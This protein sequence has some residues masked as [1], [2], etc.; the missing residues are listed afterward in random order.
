MKTIVA[1]ALGECVHVAGVHSFL[2]LAEQNGWR[3]IFL[4]PANSIQQV[5]EAAEKENADL[6][7][8]SYRLTPENGERLLAEFA[9][10]ADDL[11]SRGVKF[12]FGGTPP[13]VDRIKRLNFFE[14]HFDGSERIEEITAYLRGQDISSAQ[15]DD[16]PQSAIERIRWKSPYPL[17]R[18]HYG[19]PDLEE[20]IQ[21]IEAIAESK[22]IDV[23]SLGIDQDA[24]ENFFHPERQDIRRRGAGGVPVR[25]AEDY[26][27]LYEATR[28]GNFPLIRTYS[29]T[30]DFIRLAEMYVKTINIAWAAVPLYW[31][32]QMD[33][34][35]PWDLE[36]S[37]REHIRLMRWYGER[38]IPVEANEAH[39]WGMRDAHDVVFVVSAYLAAYNAKA[40]GVNDHIVQLMF[41]SPPG[42]SVV[43]DLAKMIAVIDMT[44]PLVSPE[45]RIW[46]QVRTG[47]LSYP[48]DLDQAR[49]HLAI[50]VFNQMQ[51]NPDIVHVVGYPEANHAVTANEVI[52][53]CMMAR[54]AID[55]AIA[56]QINVINSESIQ[57]R[58]RELVSEAGVLVKEI[59]KL[60][61]GISADPL[62]DPK[63]LA[64][65]VTSGLLDAPQLSNNQYGKGEV[66]TSFDHRGACLAIDK[67]SGKAL[68]E[69]QRLTSMQSRR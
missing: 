23:I 21:G 27:R 41:N 17:I 39:H 11:R 67:A 44:S 63:V 5:I 7:G 38:N 20:T 52:E 40:A 35:G 2:K 60:G 37:I 1:S 8:V 68:S 62:A 6:V 58:V 61:S 49:A 33:G 66:V 15:E 25:S 4:G 36:G 13:V 26:S 18:H 28:T 56:S 55:D 9:E 12:A 24:Q 64:K 57:H 54:K 59:H 43:M 48:V 3:T 69:K 16:F 46:K 30:D 34:R 22:V 14:A 10:Q 19:L 51:I 42:T 29:G 45:F 65:A 50:T 53:S 47:L 31:F 32:N